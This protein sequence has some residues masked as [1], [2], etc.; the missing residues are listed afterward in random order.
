M[1]DLLN[2]EVAADRLEYLLDV[3]PHRLHGIPDHDFNAK[4]SVAV[5]SKKEIL[6][7]LIDSAANNHQRFIRA[8]YENLPAVLY[9][10][11]KWNQLN[12]YHTADKT[13][14]INLWS[15]YNLHLL[16]VI[17]NVPGSSLLNKCHTGAKEPF[18]LA[19]LIAD[20]VDHM[21]HHLK[22]ILDVDEL[23]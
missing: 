22:Q 9:D 10:Q 11:D 14:L 1:D 20:Y 18:T 16:H 8:Q 7:H 23:H 13:L 21:E 3:V 19:F 4:P 12:V 17:R 15:N 5:W 6:G 2:A